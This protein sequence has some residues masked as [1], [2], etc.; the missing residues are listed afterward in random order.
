MHKIRITQTDKKKVYFTSDTHYSHRN[1]CRGVS[2]W[3]ERTIRKLIEDGMSEEKARIKATLEFE[4]ST[5]DFKTLAEM[6]DAL[7]EGINS[8]VGEDDILFHT[9]DWSFGEKNSAINF[10]RRLYC[11]N[12]HLIFGNHD[13]VLETDTSLH[14]YFCSVQHYK[15]IY[16]DGE[17]ICLFHYKQ[18]V[19]NK[20]HRDSYHLYGHSHSTAEHIVN[21]KSMDIGVDNAFKLLGEYRPFSFDEVQKM[22]KNRKF[23]AKDHHK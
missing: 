11:K 1:I 10:R 21:G 7:V 14:G 9:G 18:S 8:T 23:E 20:S 5:R 16:V 22:L 2:Q 4:N 12:V 19:W 6:D 15:E 3:K 13:K 17:M